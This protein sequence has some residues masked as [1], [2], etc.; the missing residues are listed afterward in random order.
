MFMKVKDIFELIQGNSFELMDMSKS[1]KANINF[2]SRASTHNG[3][4]GVVDI[5]PH[6]E[7]FQAG[8]LTVALSGNGVCS[9]FVQTKPFYTAYH[10]MV[11]KPKK[12]M[13]FNEKMYYALCIKRNAYRYAWGRQANKTLKNL[14][15][16]D[17][18][19]DYVNEIK[20]SPIS[21]V[22]TALECSL[23]PTSWKE[24]QLTDLFEIERGTRLTK[25]NRL[26]G[27][28]PLITAGF[29]NEGIAEYIY[30]DE[31]KLY[32]DKITIDMF[33]NAFYRSYEFYCDDNILVL[34]CK[35]PINKY[36]KLFLS[37]I[38]K[39]DAYRYSYG[40]Q[41]RQKDCRNHVIKLPVLSDGSPDFL[42]MEKYIKSL[43]YGDRV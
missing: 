29:Q 24:F 40:R 3:V 20:V 8:L 19:P 2:V 11:L 42:Y 33:G 36:A 1:E 18:L 22:N 28:I 37:T 6:C 41:Y 4:T 31:N 30:T 25:E 34:N 7:P 32:Y 26:V 10:V 5:L 43:R 12:H 21:T 13:T 15:L 14:E 38:I 16:P 39:A 27:E 35:I 23:D 9:T 17:I